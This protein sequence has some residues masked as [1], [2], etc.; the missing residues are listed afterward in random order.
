MQNLRRR[1]ELTQKKTGGDKR[2]QTTVTGRSQ[3]RA[4]P[5]S[6]AGGQYLHRRS[7]SRDASTG[8][9]VPVPSRRVRRSNRDRVARAADII[10]GLH[11]GALKELEKY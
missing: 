11:R 10:I 6:A 5:R 1:W 2:A 8:M 3:R 7:V 4:E 9:W